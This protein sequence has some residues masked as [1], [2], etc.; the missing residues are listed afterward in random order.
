MVVGSGVEVEVGKL[1]AIGICLSV[2]FAAKA[3]QD[4]SAMIR[5]ERTKPL[6][7]LIT[8]FLAL[9]SMAGSAQP[10]INY[11]DS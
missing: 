10:K 7:M 2:G 6:Q 11:T 3:L 8:F 4:V 5:Y 1:V 9:I